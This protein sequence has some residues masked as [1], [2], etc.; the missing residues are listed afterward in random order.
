[1]SVIDIGGNVRNGEELDDRAVGNWLIEHGEDISG[2]VEVTQY[3]GGAS[4]W[5]YRLQYE[6]ADLILRRPPKGTKAKSAHDMSREYHVQRALAEYYPVVPEM[7]LLCQDESVIGCDFY[8]MKRIEGIIPR[9]N[10]PK[11]INFDELQTRELC[12]NFIDKLIEL[13]Q[14]PYEGTEL[15]KLGKGDGYCQRQ[16]DGWDSRYEKAKT[17]NVPSFKYVR[18]W[19]KDHVPSDSKTCVIHNDWRFDNVILDPENPS[20]II[21][22]LDW[23]MATLGDPLM[24]LGSSLAY[25][26]E[27]SDNAIF[28]A[29]RRQPTHL[30]GMFTRAEVVEY[31][32]NKTGLK[33]DNWTFYEVFG[34]FRLAVIAQQ[35]YY[36]YYHKQTN[37]PAFKDF[38]IVIHALHIR[39]L[40]LIGLQKIEAND[41]AQKYIAKFK[42]LMPK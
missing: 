13:H 26:V 30:K 22:V 40:K 11:E 1:M 16:V 38:W 24:D 20:K 31:Y 9:A 7:V 35:I 3:S 14:V 27:E 39:A 5:T 41:I 4:N 10:L 36:R 23:E 12:T 6:N 33:T 28:K 17:L 15:E 29:T 18:Q 21:G 32:L 8:V 34:I 2:P 19:L 42:E 25:W 37:N